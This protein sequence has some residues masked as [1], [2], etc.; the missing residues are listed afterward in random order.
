MHSLFSAMGTKGSHLQLQCKHAITCSVLDG[1]DDDALV[2]GYK[3]TNNKFLE[4]LLP[5]ISRRR[6]DWINGCRVLRSE[7][8]NG[9]SRNI[10]KLYDDEHNESLDTYTQ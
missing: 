1:G 7:Y 3:K 4:V 5:H 8:E 10:C 9:D 6:E 2:I